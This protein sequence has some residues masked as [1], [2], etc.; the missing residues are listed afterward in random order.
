MYRVAAKSQ[1]TSNQ[2]ALAKQRFNPFPRTFMSLFTNLS[3]GTEFS[4]CM[5]SFPLNFESES[6]ARCTLLQ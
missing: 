2:V 4:G 1:E 6:K 3:Q 5:K